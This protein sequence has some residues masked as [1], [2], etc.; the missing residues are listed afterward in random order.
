MGVVKAPIRHGLTTP[1]LVNV[2]VAEALAPHCDWLTIHLF[3]KVG[4]VEAIINLCQDNSW[5]CKYVNRLTGSLS[6]TGVH[7]KAAPIRHLRLASGLVVV[8]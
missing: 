8:V 5:S 4:V 2:G 7:T 6:H 3:N 1:I